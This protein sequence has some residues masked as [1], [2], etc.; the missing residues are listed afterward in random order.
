MNLNEITQCRFCGEKCH[1]TI[2]DCDNPLRIEFDCGSSAEKY[3]DGS[4]RWPQ[5]CN[6]K[7][8]ETNIWTDP[9]RRCGSPIKGRLQEAGKYIAVDYY[10][11][12][13]SRLASNGMW[14]FDALC[15]HNC[16]PLDLSLASAEEIGMAALEAMQGPTNDSVRAKFAEILFRKLQARDGGAK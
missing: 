9:C 15:R 7:I 11:G 5:R 10:C 1:A 6:W 14:E 13:K 4:L 12:S 3:G 16:S 2:G 8:A